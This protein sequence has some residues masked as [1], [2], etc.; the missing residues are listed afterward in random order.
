MRESAPHRR[1]DEHGKIIH[2]LRGG[3][4]HVERTDDVDVHRA[5]RSVLL[6]RA[7]RHDDHRLARERIFELVPPKL[8]PQYLLPAAIIGDLEHPP[9]PPQPDNITRYHHYDASP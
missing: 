1:G 6:D 7:G 8:L 5:M 2:A 3:R 4:G 9:K